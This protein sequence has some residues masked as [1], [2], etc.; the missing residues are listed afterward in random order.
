LRELRITIALTRIGRGEKL[1]C[2]GEFG[3]ALSAIAAVGAPGMD[4]RDTENRS[5]DK[6]H[7]SKVETSGHR[8]NR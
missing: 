1:L 3:G 4:H 5:E 6:S 8:S 2:G 7:E